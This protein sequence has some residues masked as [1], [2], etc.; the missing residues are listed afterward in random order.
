MAKL[1]FLIHLIMMTVIAGVL[2]IG[3]VSVPSLAEQAKLLIPVSA[4]IGFFVAFPISIY[5]AKQIL[6]QSR[7][8]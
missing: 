1:V 6:A 2:V 8:V 3:V 7:G 5:I 4:A